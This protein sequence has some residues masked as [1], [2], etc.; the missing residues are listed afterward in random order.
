MHCHAP[1]ALLASSAVM[2]S[3]VH[4][5]RYVLTG[6]WQPACFGQFPPFSQTLNCIELQKT[7]GGPPLRSLSNYRS[8]F[9][10]KMIFPALLSRIEERR[11]VV[12][13]RV[14]RAQITSLANVVPDTCQSEIRQSGWA[15]VL[16]SSGLLTTSK[17]TRL[18]TYGSE[19][20]CQR[21][22]ETRP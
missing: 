13:F 4:D 9:K 17:S 16:A 12:G 18:S 20:A 2:G 8:V 21:I 22:A 3:T 10:P 11:Y 7:H 19:S 15:T 6:G 5:Q 14:N 1:L